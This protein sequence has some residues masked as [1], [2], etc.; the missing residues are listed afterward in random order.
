MRVNWQWIEFNV[1]H[2]TYVISET[3]YQPASYSMYSQ[4][5]LKRNRT[6]IHTVVIVRTAYVA[7]LM[8]ERNVNI[9]ES[10]RFRLNCAWC[11]IDMNNVATSS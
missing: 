11:S 8:N 3:R 2:D 1:P 6:Y 7:L 5:A 9:A 4:H 10:L